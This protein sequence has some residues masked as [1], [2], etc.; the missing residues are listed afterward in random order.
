MS[1][2]TTTRR[3]KTITKPLDP[4][5]IPIEHAVI[6]DPAPEPAHTPTTQEILTRLLT[7]TRPANRTESRLLHRWEHLTYWEKCALAFEWNLKFNKKEHQRL[8]K[9]A[10]EKLGRV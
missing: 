4:D 8:A 6:T 5:L 2:Q 7:G 1:K 3:K 9:Q 10:R